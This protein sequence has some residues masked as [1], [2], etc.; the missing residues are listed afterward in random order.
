MANASQRKAGQALARDLILQARAAG[1]AVNGAGLTPQVVQEI[2]ARFE[3]VQASH[4]AAAGD[5]RGE[6]DYWYDHGAATGALM[7]Y[8]A[9]RWGG[10]ADLYDRVGHVHDLDYLRFPHDTRKNDSEA[11]C[12]HPVPLARAM[13]ELRVH[14]AV[15]LAVLEHAP[16][17]QLNLAPTSRLSAALS[18]AEDLATAKALN[19]VFSGLDKLSEE[20]RELYGCVEVSKPIHRKHAVRVEGNPDLYINQPL[21]RITCGRPFLF[22]L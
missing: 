15:I 13:L 12:V 7:R 4:G 19:P 6:Q 1:P 17:L 11:E 2:T 21:A 14:P 9:Q 16:Y 20:A 5:G 8:I 3:P 18:A 22:D 10:D